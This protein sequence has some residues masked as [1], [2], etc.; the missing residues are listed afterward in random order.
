VTRVFARWRLSQAG[1]E[2]NPARPVELG[3]AAAQ[4]LDW[5]QQASL[6]VGCLGDPA[7]LRTALEVLTFRLDASRAAA[8]TIIRKRVVLHGALGYA[9]EAGLLPDNQLDSIG[10]QVPQTSTALDPAAVA[11]PAQVSALLERSPGPSR[12]RP[13]SSAACT[14]PR[15]ARRKPSPCA[16][17][18]ADCPAPDGACSGQPRPRPG[19]PAW[20]S[21]G[22]PWHRSRLQNLDNHDIGL[23]AAHPALAR[24]DVHAENPGR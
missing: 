16:S 23:A 21:S 19:P 22:K 12:R 2:H 6:S 10:W 20:T 14:T 13:P 5:A 11:S 15:F 24:T 4:I 17:P 8:N 18:T 1:V 9:A 7:V 3:S